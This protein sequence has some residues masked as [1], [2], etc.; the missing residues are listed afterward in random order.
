MYMHNYNSAQAFQMAVPKG[1]TSLVSKSSNSDGPLQPYS[2]LMF[3]KT[4]FPLRT[5]PS[6]KS[7]R[8][9]SSLTPLNH[10]LPLRARLEKYPSLKFRRP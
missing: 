4:E 10:D 3:E 9:Y 5:C 2:P 1:C 7:S 8:S 6:Q